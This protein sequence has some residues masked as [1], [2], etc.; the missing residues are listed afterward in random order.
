MLQQP[1]GGSGAGAGAASG[2]GANSIS[3]AASAASAASAAASMSALVNQDNTGRRNERTQKRRELNDDEKQEVKQAF[4]L[5]D[6]D[7]DGALDYHELKVK[8]RPLSLVLSFGLPS[9]VG[10]RPSAPVSYS[11]SFPLAW[12]V[13]VSLPFIF[14]SFLP[15][16]LLL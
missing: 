6:T 2:T 1:S 11:L 9:A 16:S 7:K 12:P 8:L 3:A 10:R 4:D 15:V 13:V 14:V 5:F